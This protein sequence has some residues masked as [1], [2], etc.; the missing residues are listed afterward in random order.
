VNSFTI[1]ESLTGVEYPEVF[2]DSGYYRWF[3]KEDSLLV[4][5]IPGYSFAM[6]G[7][8]SKM[9]GTL[10]LTPQ[11]LS[12]D[13][14]AYVDD[15]EVESRNLKY[16]HHV[17]NADTSNF[18]LKT[19]DKTDL[20][21]STV[22]YSA[23]I[24]MQ[25]RTGEF[26][27]TGGASQVNL[28]AN[29][30]ICFMDQFEWS[31]DSSIISL[32]NTISVDTA[33][34]NTLTYSGLIDADLSGA[35]FISTHPRQ[36]SLSFFALKADYDLKQNI[37]YAE[38]VKLIKVADA[39]VFPYD[40]KVQI[41]KDA[42]MEPLRNAVIIADTAYKSHLIYDATVS[43]TSRNQYKASGK[44]DYTDEVGDVQQIV[45]DNITTDEEYRT[46]AVAQIADSVKFSLS[47]YFD[48]RGR[49]LLATS[50]EFL[51]FDGGF[52]IRQDCDPMPA[53]WV[54]FMAEVDPNNIFLPVPDTV[55]DMAG[56]RISDAVVLS[57][58]FDIYPAFFGRKERMDETEIIT[59]NGYIH[60]LKS[61]QEFVITSAD[62]FTG[63]S[64]VDNLLKMSLKNCVI[65]GQGKVDP[66]VNFGEV[67][68]QAYGDAAYYMIPDSA[69]F[70]LL[71]NF[72]FFFADELLRIVIG[73]LVLADLPGVD[74]TKE[75]YKNALACM[76]G[77]KT[78]D[79]LITELSLYGNLRRLPPELQHSMVFSDVRLTWN[80]RTRSYLSSGPLGISSILDRSINKYVN[81]TIELA[82]R[83]TGDELNIY[84]ETGQ[85]EWFY[86]NYSNHIMQSIS[87]VNDYNNILSNMKDDKRIL[88]LPDTKE[89][90]QFIISTP[91]KMAE[92]MRRT[93]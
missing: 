33:R 28:P 87:S 52:R 41:K 37:L 27:S 69:V 24:D 16:G 46:Y 21:L 6:F 48:F 40:G 1:Q 49:I 77:Q 36:D 31:M 43:I 3:P 17:F 67:T 93:Q 56:K 32:Q 72:D 34:V 30:Y 91:Q 25:N 55:Y 23:F 18:R 39:A 82:K 29:D 62:R 38:D 47:P 79:E 89:V 81:G 10:K 44:Y 84:I 80:D 11:L 22:G 19:I 71:L 45:F 64:M 59:A 86:F 73:K 14:I 66:G 65:A 12:G 8:Q 78:A 61:A 60:Y 20:A 88:D 51:T 90:Y 4:T 26:H 42:V 58:G 68:Y 9:T 2:A 5:S 54:R 83:R 53:S 13:G 85:N 50:R 15:G 76:V 74:I 57:A 63:K 7:N 35:A 70:N 92:F 75:S